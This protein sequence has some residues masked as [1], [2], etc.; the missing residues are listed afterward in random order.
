VRDGDELK[1]IDKQR[2]F[3]L[4]RHA[5]LIQAVPRCELVMAQSNVLIGIWR[6][7]HT[8]RKP[9]AHFA[10]AHDVRDKFESRAIPCKQK[11]ARR[12]LAIEL[13]DRDGACRIRLGLKNA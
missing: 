1:A 10:A 12:R 8:G 3:E 13:D 7:A 2:L 4:V 9:C 6:V 11:R 5:Q